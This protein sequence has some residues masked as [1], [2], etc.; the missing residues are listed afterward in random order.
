MLYTT[1]ILTLGGIVQTAFGIDTA[2]HFSKGRS[3]TSSAIFGDLEECERMLSSPVSSLN[4]YLPSLSM[5]ANSSS[6]FGTE[7]SNLA[8]AATVVTSATNV[9]S[10]MARSQEVI[11]ASSSE[12]GGEIYLALA[13]VAGVSSRIPVDNPRLAAFVAKNVVDDASKYASSLHVG[14]SMSLCAGH[15]NSAV[16]FKSTIMQWQDLMNLSFETT[17]FYLPQ[18]G[19]VCILINEIAKECIYH[20]SQHFVLHPKAPGRYKL[21]LFLKGPIYNQ[22]FKYSNVATVHLVGPVPREWPDT[23]SGAKVC[24]F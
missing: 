20:E 6:P 17:R 24:I 18:D 15:S 8:K 23:K 13:A 16:E 9:L 1:L 10:K 3:T 21:Q 22:I 14:L 12:C 11:V 4:L 2:L 19:C 7:L 5:V